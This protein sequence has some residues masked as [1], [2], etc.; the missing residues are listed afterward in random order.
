MYEKRTAE[1]IIAF[2]SGHEGATGKEIAKALGECKPSVSWTLMR[3]N[4]VG[5][6]ERFGKGNFQRRLTGKS[7]LKCCDCCGFEVEA[8]RINDEGV[9]G[10]CRQSEAGSALAANREKHLLAKPAYEPEHLA[11]LQVNRV[12][13][14]PFG[15]PVE[16]YQNV[17]R[18][19]VS[20]L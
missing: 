13:Q 6:V 17:M 11:A 14:K 15:Q 3:L 12:L 20:C 18:G 9:C 5:A 16:F 7:H 19:D 2:L 4:K 8:W 1:K 10:S